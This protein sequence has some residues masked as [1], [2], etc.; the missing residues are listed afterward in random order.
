MAVKFK[1]YYDIL[2]VKRSATQD[3]VKKAYRKLARKYHPD[4][5]KEPGAEG[6]FKEITEA[7]EVLGNKDNRK[8]YDELGANWKAGQE[9]SPPPD[10]ENVHFEFHKQGDVGAIFEDLG[11]PSDFFS[12][13]FGDAFHTGSGRH[14]SGSRGP[15]T[16]GMDHEAEITISL[17]EAYN[18]ARKSISMQTAELDKRGQVKRNVKTYAVTI[19]AG[20]T[21]QSRIRLAG[22]G[23]QGQG[24]ASAGDLYL[25]VNVAPHPIFRLKGKD[26]ERDL[27]ISPWEAALGNNIAVPT[28][29]G[30][31]TLKIPAG[32][33]GGQRLRL[34]GKGL[35]AR[36]GKD[37]GDL[38]I[39]I[40]IKVPTHLDS[41]EKELFEKLAKQSTF[42]PRKNW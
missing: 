2:G 1:D 39:T 20:T 3:D 37:I 9:F 42:N 27:P 11:G 26:L 41:G 7:Y 34:R 17:D 12:T 13:L 23:G 18:G 21:H 28:M 22:Q 15:S 36:T 32:V 30:K 24:G 5:S 10:W 35:P 29:N 31:A 14:S 6:K 33:Q 4:V 16:R 19:P 8:K 38:Y 40:I 25:R